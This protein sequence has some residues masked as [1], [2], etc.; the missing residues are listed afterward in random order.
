MEYYNGN[1]VYNN[2]GGFYDGYVDP[3]MMYNNY[4][5]YNAFVPQK[6]AIPQ[7]TD[8]MSPEES[9]ELWNTGSNQNK[10]DLNVDSIEYKRALCN[11]KENGKD[12]VQR[13]NDGSGDVWCPRCKVRWN[14]N[15]VDPETLKNG[16]K[17]VNDAMQNA[18]WVGDLP[19]TVVRDYFSLMPLLDKLPDIYQVSMNNFDKYYNQHQY[20]S[21]KDA[22][23]YNQFNSLFYPNSMQPMYAPQPMQQVPQNPYYPQPVMGYQPQQPV[24]GQVAVPNVNPMQVQ[25]PMGYQPQ[26]NVPYQQ[27]MQVNPYVPQPPV[28]QPVQQQQQTVQP[29]SSVTIT[30]NGST[31]TA[32]INGTTSNSKT[33]I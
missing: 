17:I 1:D 21:A 2:G 32:T 29:S 7:N 14:P 25:Q 33:D 4:Y 26:Q 15:A 22:D 11:H 24:Y 16:I 6:Y 30:P 9:K 12:L 13:I 31:V 10:L 20:L 23:V 19:V 28:Q 8:S 27:P 3:N 5:P 18:K